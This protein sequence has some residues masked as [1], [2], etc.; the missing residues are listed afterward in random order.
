MKRRLG[1][2]LVIFILLVS[3]FAAQKPVFMLVNGQWAD[4][5]LSDFV[6]V[7]WHG[8]TLDVPMAGYL[9]ALPLLASIV[10]AW[11]H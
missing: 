3:V 1:Y 2:I 4:M 11:W 5:A 6:N 10:S 9:V 7:I 8:L